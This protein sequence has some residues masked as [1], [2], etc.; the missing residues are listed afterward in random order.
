VIVDV[1]HR[2]RRGV[3]IGLGPTRIPWR[4]LGTE[5]DLAELPPGISGSQT[6]SER[7][8]P[9]LSVHRSRGQ[10]DHASDACLR[11]N[12]S[13]SVAMRDSTDDLVAAM[14]ESVLERVEPTRPPRSL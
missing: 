11:N 2:V 12:A 10:S 1:L 14:S 3:H 9:R 5:P 7:P 8:A 13:V 6:T 4:R